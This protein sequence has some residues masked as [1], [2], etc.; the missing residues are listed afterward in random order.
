MD[1]DSTA[2]VIQLFNLLPYTKYRNT[3]R[4]RV[5]DPDGIAP[6]IHNY[7]GGGGRHAKIIQ[8]GRWY[9]SDAD[10]CDHR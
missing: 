4:G 2:R 9:D 6:T 1:S 7:A 10:R 5:Y 3:H 8:Y